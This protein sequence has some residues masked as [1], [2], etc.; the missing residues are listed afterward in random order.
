MVKRANK[1]LVLIALVILVFGIVAR[2]SIPIL[3]SDVIVYGVKAISPQR[4]AT[5]IL[6]AGLCLLFSSIFIPRFKTTLKEDIL[7]ASS[8]QLLLSSISFVWNNIVPVRFE[9]LNT[10]GIVG[11]AVSA[12]VLIVGL[13]FPTPFFPTPPRKP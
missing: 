8:L 7:L 13:F 3:P 2:L 5:Y 10:Y 4:Y 6:V 12:I 1:T 9:P 11:I